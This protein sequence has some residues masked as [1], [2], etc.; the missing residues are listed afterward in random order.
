MLNDYLA[1]TPPKFETEIEFYAWRKRYLSDK[2]I[3]LPPDP[4][5][6]QYQENLCKQMVSFEMDP[7]GAVCYLWDWGR[8]ELKGY[9]P[10]NWQL[11][12]LWEWG[13]HLQNPATRFMPFNFAV[14]SGHGI[15]KS[16]FVGMIINISLSTFAFTRC[17]TTANTENQLLR[18]TWP[19]VEK[20]L[21]LS[22]TSSWFEYQKTSLAAKGK[23]GATWRADA[24]T[25]SITN[26]SAFAGLHNHGK[27][28]LIIFD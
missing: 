23:S 3:P 19:E 7:L 10:E 13:R 24:I 16:A 21:N 28:I 14:A 1:D 20:W 22:I 17:R 4:T 8:G 18:L 5:H 15:G 11:E 9:A 12:A 26:T 25:W 6:D 27:R 2:L